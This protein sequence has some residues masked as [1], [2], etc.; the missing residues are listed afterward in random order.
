[1]IFVYCTRKSANAFGQNKLGEFLDNT[2]F[3]HDYCFE[4]VH[5]NRALACTFNNEELVFQRVLT[6]HVYK[7][8]NLHKD[9]VN[10]NK[11]IMI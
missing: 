1:M 10:S 11:F 4:C 8:C 7:H 6:L 5:C 3:N 9:L 2:L